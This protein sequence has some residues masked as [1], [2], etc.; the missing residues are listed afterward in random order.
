MAVAIAA[1]G[2]CASCSHGDTYPLP[3]YVTRQ[4]LDTHVPIQLTYAATGAAGPSFTWDG[5]DLIIASERPDRGP[6]EQCLVFLPSQGGQG[7]RTVCANGPGQGDSVD[8]LT[9]GAMGPGGR[10]VY[11][12][13]AT[14]DFRLGWARRELVLLDPDSL[15]EH[16]ITPIPFVGSPALNDNVTQARW[17]DHDRFVYR[18]DNS[19]LGGSPPFVMLVDLRTDPA[20]FTVLPFTTGATSVDVVSP[21]TI[22]LTFPGSSQVFYQDIGTG[23][24]REAW[25]FPDTVAQARYGNGYIAA[26]LGGT[27]GPLAIVD[28][29]TA[30]QG[31]VYAG[32]GRYDQIALSPD[33]HRLVARDTRHTLWLFPFR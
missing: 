29:V 4:P 10:L 8:V 6:G 7:E 33:G 9:S 24:M 25:N 23:A 26:I 19:Y 32:A 16:L 28:L 18:G 2:C 20:T 21:D 5:A 11:L 12:H 30:T 13:S 3:T 31:L 27:S 1:A 17:L 14:L 22:I 15:G